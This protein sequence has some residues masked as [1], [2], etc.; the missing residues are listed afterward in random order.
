MLKGLAD[1]T[2]TVHLDGG[3]LIVE[4]AQNNRVFMTGPADEVFEGDIKI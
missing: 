1:R 3:D 4:W 2:I